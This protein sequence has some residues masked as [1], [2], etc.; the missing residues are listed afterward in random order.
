MLFLH[1]SLPSF[2]CSFTLCFEVTCGGISSHSITHTYT[3]CKFK[4][5]HWPSSVFFS[6]FYMGCS[7]TFFH[8]YDCVLHR[9]R[10]IV[11]IDPSFCNPNIDPPSAKRKATAAAH[12]PAGAVAPASHP[13]PRVLRYNEESETAP[14]PKKTKTAPVGTSTPLAD[15]SAAPTS[16]S[17]PKADL[18]AHADT[19]PPST[20]SETVDVEDSRQGKRRRMD[21]DEVPAA[22]A[23]LRKK[24]E[25]LAPDSQEEAEDE[26]GQ[27]EPSVDT[28]TLPHTTATTTATACTS[29]AARA[30]VDQADEEE[31]DHADSA[32]KAR[33]AP[34]APVK[35][36]KEAWVGPDGTPVIEVV[37][38]VVDRAANKKAKAA[39]TTDS[40]KKN[41][42][43]FRK[44]KR[45]G[46]VASIARRQ[47][48]DV[49]EADCVWTDEA[50]REMDEENERYRQ[51]DEHA[52]AEEDFVPK[53][54]AV[55]KPVD[56]SKRK[57]R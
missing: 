2:I 34:K 38:L 30:D 28:L 45:G 35:P 21:E 26:P 23:T 24:V 36:T 17:T 46:G 3:R 13:P 37:S 10:G 56:K 4:Y 55:S 1:G 20:A 40:G 52:A 22:R 53:E 47:V 11:F 15:R 29:A 48:I 33:K 39:K 12:P 6:F 54:K 41:F 57:R 18:A 43:T 50:L 5:L 42:K 16:T 49:V 9:Y 7:R 8:S 19:H 44:G 51:A 27:T 31:E 14:S 32:D 25:I